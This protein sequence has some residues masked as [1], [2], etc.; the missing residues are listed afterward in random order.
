M[1]EKERVFL[2]LPVLLLVLFL[3]AA[4]AGATC[5]GDCK[6]DADSCSLKVT[7]GEPVVYTCGTEETITAR[8]YSLSDGSL[9][10]VKVTLPD[11]KVYT[12]PAVLS[13]SGVRYTD[14]F[15]LVWW[16]KGDTAFAEKRGDNGEWKTLYQECRIVPEKK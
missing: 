10:F 1:K 16:T 9:H 5:G 11:G 15:E 8:Y 6:G 14:D 2:F 3:A 7:G 12:L 4:P 13:A